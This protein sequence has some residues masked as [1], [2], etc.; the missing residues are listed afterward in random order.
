MLRDLRGSAPNS[1]LEDSTV[2]RSGP[3]R[4]HGRDDDDGNENTLGSDQV[5]LEDSSNSMV[6]MAISLDPLT[7]HKA[8]GQ[9][10]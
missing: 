2:S 8:L 9:I 7:A 1:H 3:A 10:D 5:M 4:G 6:N